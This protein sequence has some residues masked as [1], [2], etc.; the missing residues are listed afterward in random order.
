MKI[1]SI[2]L[3]KGGSVVSLPVTSEVSITYKFIGPEDGPHV[4]EVENEDHIERLLA[5]PEGFKPYREP[6]TPEELAAEHARLQREE[7]ERIEAGRKAQEEA[8]KAEAERLA[9]EEA[10]RERLQKLSQMVL[11]NRISAAE[12]ELV[13]AGVKPM[14]EEPKEPVTPSNEPT[15]AQKA[16]MKLVADAKP[17]VDGGDDP[18][19]APAAKSEL[20]QARLAFEAAFG[21]KAP[22]RASAEALLAKV[23]EKNGEA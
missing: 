11:E 9:R 5:I 23:A 20:A 3:R 8:A 18:K 16:Q 4:C 7:A 13:R 10:E 22:V 1:E 14:P 15:E 17:T 21:R 19:P 2:L 6:L 12:A